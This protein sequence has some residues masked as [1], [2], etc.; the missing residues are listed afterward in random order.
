MGGERRPISWWLAL[1]FFFFFFVYYE[2]WGG[3]GTA[4]RV[5]I[6]IGLEHRLARRGARGCDGSEALGDVT[7]CMLACLIACFLGGGV[8]E[9]GVGEAGSVGCLH[10]WAGGGC[11][12]GGRGVNEDVFT[13]PHPVTRTRTLRSSRCCLCVEATARLDAA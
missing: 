2:I 6:G 7:A 10:I 11:G 5:G 8:L 3:G 9:G 13:P 4:G 12:I 1:V